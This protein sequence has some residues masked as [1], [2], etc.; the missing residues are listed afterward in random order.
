M[1]KKKKSFF[2]MPERLHFLRDSGEI[3]CDLE[4]LKALQWKRR[5][6]GAGCT[7]VVECLP[8]MCEA[9]DSTPT[10]QRK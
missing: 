8:S 6:A 3:I 4:T 9:L 2:G 10:L 7:S 1:L 5:Q